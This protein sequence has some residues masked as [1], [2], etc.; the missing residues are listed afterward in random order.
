[1]ARDLSTFRLTRR[2]FLIGA[3]VAVGS[4]SGMPSTPSCALTAEQELGPYYID[5]EKLRQ[6]ITEGR[7]GVPVKLRVA[8][9]DAAR[10]APLQNAS[11]DIWHCDALGVYSGFTANSPDGDMRGPVDLRAVGL[12]PAD[13]VDRAAPALVVWDLP[14]CAKPTP[15]ASCAAYS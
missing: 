4:A 9:V 12:R 11:L 13:R 10:C 2:G 15:P 6:D 14:R 5:D 1:M 8:L 7:P 3:A